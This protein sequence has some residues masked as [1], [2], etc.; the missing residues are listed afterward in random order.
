MHD[1]RE[2][3]CQKFIK[4]EFYFHKDEV[5]EKRIILGE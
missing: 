2:Y 4:T 3:G 1:R 5:L